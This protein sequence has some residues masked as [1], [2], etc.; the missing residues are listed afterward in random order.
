MEKKFIVII[1]IIFLFNTN[2]VNADTN[3]IENQLKESTT[4]KNLVENNHKIDIS[5]SKKD[6][7]IVDEYNNIIVVTTF[8]I[9]DNYLEFTSSEEKEQLV[10]KAIWI[11]E[12]NRI[13]LKYNNYS[14]DI[15]NNFDI[16]KYKYSINGVE[17]V[18]NSFIKGNK[19]L[20][21]YFYYKV[22]LSKIDLDKEESVEA[23]DKIEGNPNKFENETEK[24]KTNLN[25]DKKN[26]SYTLFIE[27][28]CIIIG[29]FMLFISS[30]TKNQ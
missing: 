23:I 8:N 25:K 16:S 28:F 13:L 2:V 18:K 4:L 27:A 11:E 21:Y 30:A 3:Y 14:D 22:N 10:N 19:E 1:S 5:S 7:K 17:G 6:I 20:H 24:S 12:I 9:K 26:M 29:I 15:I